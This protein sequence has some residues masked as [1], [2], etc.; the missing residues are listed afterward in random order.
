MKSLLD[1]KFANVLVV[2]AH[3]D[4]EALFCGGT[5]RRLRD[6]KCE[7]SIAVTASVTVTNAPR[8]LSERVEN[9][10]NRQQRRLVAFGRVC[11][12]LDAT[13]TFLLDTHNCHGTLHDEP[14]ETRKAIEGEIAERLAPVIA[15]VNPDAI[16]THGSIGEYGHGQ[17]VLT[18]SVVKDL[19]S[20]PMWCFAATG[21]ER[22]SID[23][24][25]KKRLLACYRYGTT[26]DPYWTPYLAAP[27]QNAIGPWLGDEER[28]E[29]IR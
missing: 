13:K 26:Q 14:A 24:E 1:H 28:F 27:G 8:D 15:E 10:S 16:I 18:H 22:V 6:Q 5:L 9:E 21:G 2:G 12:M 25:F 23:L 17:H 20:G 29:R 3:F 7:L 19:W 11:G 4:D